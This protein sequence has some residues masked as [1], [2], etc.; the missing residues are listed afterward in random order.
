MKRLGAA[1]GDGS[2][3]GGPTAVA[4]SSGHQGQQEVRQLLNDPRGQVMGLG[5]LQEATFLHQVQ[6]WD[7]LNVFEN[8]S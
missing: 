5:H 3:H 2:G 8:A 6:V 4:A 1:A 7:M